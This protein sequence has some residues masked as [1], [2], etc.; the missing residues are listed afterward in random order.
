M[1]SYNSVIS[2]SESSHS[3]GT[4]SAR[5]KTRS[6]VL[7][8]YEL[9]VIGTS[10]RLKGSRVIERGVTITENPILSKTYG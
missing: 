1:V 2:S 8:N 6:E 5:V 4:Y 10:K 9:L 3:L 7:L